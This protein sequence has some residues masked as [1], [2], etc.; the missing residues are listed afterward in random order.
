MQ[1][2]KQARI[3]ALPRKASLPPFFLSILCTEKAVPWSWVMK[4]QDEKTD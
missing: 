2:H 3:S 4:E 1:N